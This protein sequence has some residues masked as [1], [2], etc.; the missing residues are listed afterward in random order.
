MSYWLGVVRRA[1]SA[2]A[3]RPHSFPHKTYRCQLAHIAPVLALA[4][5]VCY[6]LEAL[7]RQSTLEDISLEH[8][9]S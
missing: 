8:E 1:M 3:I 4:I 9:V 7:D 5:L 2:G 6:F